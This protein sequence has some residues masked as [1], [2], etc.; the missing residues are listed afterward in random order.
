M[1]K[2]IYNKRKIKNS[3][4]LEDQIKKPNKKDYETS[5][6]MINP[7]GSYDFEAYANALEEYSTY[8]ESKLK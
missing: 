5:G 2:I 7:Y 6:S 3:S 8:L 4:S 1:L